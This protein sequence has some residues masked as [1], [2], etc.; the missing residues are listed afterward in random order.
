MAFR[1]LPFPYWL[2]F[3]FLI[4]ANCIL[5]NSDLFY[6]P[7]EAN[8]KIIAEFALKDTSCGTSHRITNFLFSRAKAT[9]VDG[10]IEAIRLK[11][12]SN[13]NVPD[14]TP[15]RCKSINLNL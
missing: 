6:E 3:P 10:C 14:P 5:Q 7:G 2:V 11:S 9:D 13:W 1:L 4:L 8:A 12:C 15:D